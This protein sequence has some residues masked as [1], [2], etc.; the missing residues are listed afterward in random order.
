VLA[1]RCCIEHVCMV[2]SLVFPSA[3]DTKLKSQLGQLGEREAAQRRPAVETLIACGIDSL[4]GLYE[5]FD[6][7][8]HMAAHWFRTEVL[9]SLNREEAASII[10]RELRAGLPTAE[11]VD[12]LLQ[13]AER[14]GES[15]EIQSEY[16]PIAKSFRRLRWTL[17]ALGDLKPAEGYDLVYPAYSAYDCIRDGHGELVR[18]LYQI[19]PGRARRDFAA[20][21]RDER[22]S[23]R[24]KGAWSFQQV[25]SAPDCDQAAALHRDADQQVRDAA[26]QLIWF[27]D[28]D[29]LDLLIDLS[30]HDNESVRVAAGMRL[31][32]LAH[33]TERQAKDLESAAPAP[34]EKRNAWRAWWSRHRDLSPEELRQRGLQRAL[35]QAH[36]G[37]DPELVGFLSGYAESEAVYTLIEA[38]LASTDKSLAMAGRRAIGQMVAQG[39][40]AASELVLRYCEGKPLADTIGLAGVLAQTND[41]R[42]VPLLL[43]MLE[44]DPGE[45]KAWPHDVLAAIGR[46]RD[47][48][49]VDAVLRWMLEKTDGAEQ[50]AAGILPQLEGV[51]PV[52][53][54]LLRRLSEES[55]HNA[56]FAL[57]TTI[58]QIDGP[59]LP[60]RLLAVLPDA[61]DGDERQAGPR[62]DILQLMEQFP[63]PAAKPALRDLLAGSSRFTRLYAARAL[64]KLGDA[65][66]VPILLQDLF[67]EEVVPYHFYAHDIGRALN[68]I[69]APD[70]MPRLTSLLDRAGGEDRKRVL[71][72]ISQQDRREWLP[73]LEALLNREDR[74]IVQAAAQAIGSLLSRSQSPDPPKVA[75]LDDA[76]LAAVTQGL[77]WAFHDQRMHPDDGRFPDQRLLAE[78][79]E[80]ILKLTR[81]QRIHYKTA[82]RSCNVLLTLQDKELISHLEAAPRQSVAH[83]SV[84]IVQHEGYLML[85]MDINSGGATYLFR[86]SGG[87]W[88]PVCSLGGWIE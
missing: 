54:Q 33:L 56:R 68:D 83:G 67:T 53:P 62:S 39:H 28:R 59:E 42:A 72:V 8:P 11:R 52:Q 74:S 37:L 13:R 47:R 22:P 78:H 41:P 30:G 48:R 44:Q 35:Q 4:S 17:Q 76:G 82:D 64:A 66:G 34:A 88:T 27:L 43:A 9:P 10:L 86:R 5:F 19:D 1:N 38:A 73:F 77:R 60:A 46:T 85:G 80:A 45:N 23:R 32:V 6:E 14:E 71:K 57:R 31:R 36:R 70:T 40:T 65:A 26:Y 58:A 3:G 20:L 51:E 75:P 69:G 2:L 87:A 81:H 79:D 61:P 55:N 25:A 50:H 63:D 12:E 16:E 21:L 84:T 29:C 18:A 15:P 24:A 7:L 49:A